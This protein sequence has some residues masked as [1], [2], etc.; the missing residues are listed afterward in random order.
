[1][2]NKMAVSI[3]VELFGPV[4]YYV[5]EGA[6]ENE[7]EVKNTQITVKTLHRYFK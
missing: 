6:V 3:E 2:T 7:H 1:M 4:C 5:L